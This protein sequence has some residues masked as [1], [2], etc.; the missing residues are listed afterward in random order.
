MNILSITAGAAE[1]YCGSCLRD[2]A[3]A[4][5]AA[6]ARASGDAAA[7][8]HADRDRRAEHER[9]PPRVLRRHQ[10][11]P[12]AAPL[13]LPPHA[14]AARSALGR[15]G[16]DQALRQ[17]VRSTSIR[18]CSARSPCRR[19][20]GEGGYQ[21]KEVEKLVALAR[22]R[23]AARCRQPAELDAH[24]AGRARS[25]ARWTGRSWSR[26]RATTCFSTGCSEPYRSRR[27]STLIRQ[28]VD[29][30][31]LLRLGERVLHRLHVRVSATS[32]ADRI[33]TVPLGVN[34][35]DLVP[36]TERRRL[37]RPER[38]FTI[39]YFARIAPEKGLHNLAEA[40]RILRQERGLPPSRLRAAGY[41]ARRAAAVSRRASSAS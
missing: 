25:G 19:C 12:A 28:Q 9:G 39:G 17:R 14:V 41:M 13:D 35:Q 3:L 18:A 22:R 5:A 34:V 11:V 30:V 2:N 15:A 27:R 20:K 32:R 36:R 4:A 26:C 16:G 33:R 37:S 1:M 31:D 7:G 38:P 8:L 10:R 40:Y 24:R 6:R 23:A 21:R 29:D